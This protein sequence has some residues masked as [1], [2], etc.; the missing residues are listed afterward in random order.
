MSRTFLRFPGGKP[1]ALTFSCDDGVTQD[2]RLVDIFDRHGLKGTFNLNS[3]GLS[4]KEAISFYQAGGHEIACHGLTH[5]F[6]EK[7]PGDRALHEIFTDRC[8][9]ESLT[10]SMVRG[11]AY[12]WGTFDERTVEAAKAAGIVYS[13]TIAATGGFGIPTD[14]LRWHPTCH[15]NDPRLM[16][17]AATFCKDNPDA[18]PHNRDP[19]LFYIWGHSY[20]FDAANNWE[21]IEQFA[22]TV[23][24]K[25]E[26]W[27]ATNMEIHDY[28]EA[29]RVLDFSADGSVVH[30]PFAID[31]WLERDGKLCCVKGGTPLLLG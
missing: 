26:V 14:W 25:E 17:L 31:L 12:P 5:D 7:L 2:R 27:Y 13:R 22:D 21:R 20:E 9:L 3:V 6:L 19:W 4:G 16:E 24:G 28:V 18:L 10:G 29:Y 15:H 11:M 30:N 23:C 8:N 1:K